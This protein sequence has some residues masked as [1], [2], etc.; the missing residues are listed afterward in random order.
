MRQFERK[1]AQNLVLVTAF[2]LLIFVPA[3]LMWAPAGDS[4]SEKRNLAPLPRLEP[5]RRSIEAY[6]AKFEKFANDHFGLRDA[7]LDLQSG[8]NRRVFHESTSRKVIFGNDGWLFYAGDFSVDDMLR[9]TRF[10]GEE[11]E[12]WKD[13]LHQRDAWLKAQGIA[14]RFVVPPDKHTVYRD[15]L[16]ARYRVPGRSRFEHLLDYLGP[17]PNLVD[18]APAMLAHKHGNGHDLPY[19]RNDTHWTS[20]GAYVGYRIIMS[21]LGKEFAANSLNLPESAIGADTD[22]WRIDLAQMARMATIDKSKPR[23][24]MKAACGHP[25]QA[26]PPPGTDASGFIQFIA[27]VCPGKR[28]T[29][30]IFHDSFAEALMPYLDDSFG[31]VVYAWGEPSDELFKRMVQQEKPDVVIEERVERSMQYVPEARL[32]GTA[33][34]ANNARE[35]SAKP[36]QD[37]YRLIQRDAML[38]AAPG[39]MRIVVGDNTWA[40]VETGNTVSGSVD[41]LQQVPEGY[42]VTGWAGFPDRKIAAESVIVASGSRIL[43]VAPTS[44]AREDV[45]QYFSMPALAQSGF[46]FVIPRDLVESASGPLRIFAVHGRTVAPIAVPANGSAPAQATSPSA[47]D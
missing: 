46:S 37:A 11:L 10:S 19:F 38:T 24:H 36:I 7:F 18:L 43:F 31:R 44:S 14:Y 3:I 13:S 9:K 1:T 33:D 4:A 35:P 42:W 23:P 45:A 29:L 39:G 21:S 30:L 17:T 2:S 28:G 26:M 27:H 6:P 16:P 47:G 20:Y 5:T 22:P 8:I 25:A 34:R 12:R 15:Q 41:K 40:R 32:D